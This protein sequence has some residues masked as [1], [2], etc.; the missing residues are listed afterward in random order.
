LC[1]FAATCLPRFPSEQRAQGKRF[2]FIPMSRVAYTKVALTYTQ[3]L[4]QLKK[5]GLHIPDE[6]YF[7][8]L[9][10]VKS[11]YRLSGYWYP[12]LENKE[13]HIFKPGADFD[14][15]YKIYCFDRELRHFVLAELEKIEIGIR[16]KMIYILSHQFGPFWYEEHTLFRNE[17]K[18][19]RLME[20]LQV[21]YDRGD[22]EFILAFKNKYTNPLPPSWILME[23]TSFGSLS[24]IYSNLKP[25]KVK[26]DIAKEFGLADS[27][28]SS[29]IHSIVYLRNVCAHHSRLWNRVMSIQPFIPRRTYSQWLIQNNVPNNTTYF[30]LSMLVYLMNRIKY[31]N[32]VVE[33]FKNLLTKYPNIHPFAMGFPENWRNEPLWK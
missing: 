1:I 13:E 10:E 7:L 16:A 19:A 33:R 5:R 11:Y 3:Q 32:D 14:T 17:E 27:V 6:E 26:R 18:H 24:L 2:I 4:Q 23:V 30:I 8:H 20:K 22:E 25:G 9:L 29:W 12:L 28:F 15:A 31:E 21:E